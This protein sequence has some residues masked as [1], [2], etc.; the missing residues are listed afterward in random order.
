MGGWE[1]GREQQEERKREASLV[2]RHIQDPPTFFPLMVT[3]CS[4][5]SELTDSSCS[6]D[7]NPKPDGK[8]SEAAVSEQRVGA[9]VAL[10]GQTLTAKTVAAGR[11]PLLIVHDVDVDDLRR[12]EQ[13]DGKERR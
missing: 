7:R 2:D 5:T 10:I 4:A 12:R 3:K 6:K 9:S 8:R 1:G 11:F 13:G